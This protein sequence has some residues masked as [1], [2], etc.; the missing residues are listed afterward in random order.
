MQPLQQFSRIFEIG[1]SDTFRPASNPSIV[2]TQAARQPGRAHVL[3]IRN[4]QG[5]SRKSTTAVHVA[6]AL[7]GD[8]AP[9]ATL[10]PDARQGTL[11]PHIENRAGD[12]TRKSVEP[13]I[14]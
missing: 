13:A 6:V 10:H 3:V 8:R 5:G 7:I 2:Q 14:P 11:G 12:A 9:L 1:M 4:E